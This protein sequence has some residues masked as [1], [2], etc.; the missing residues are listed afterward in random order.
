MGRSQVRALR[1][2]AHARSRLDDQPGDREAGGERE[3]EI[4]A[5][6]CPLF[7][8]LVEEGEIDSQIAT[9]AAEKYLAPLKEL[10]IDTLVL[11]C[12]HYPLLRDVIDRVMGN[13]VTLVDSAQAT[14]DEVASLLVAHNLERRTSDQKKELFFVTDAT[15]RFHSIAERI[16]GGPLPHLEAVELGMYDSTTV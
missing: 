12:T 10:D 3:L 13:G 14:A 5:Q 2:R 6:A 11:G 1:R 4:F 7:V 15:N 9:L 8:P 16:L